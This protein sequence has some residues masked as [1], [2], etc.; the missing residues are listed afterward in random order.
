MPGLA[1]GLGMGPSAASVA[2]TRASAV[3]AHLLMAMTGLMAFL[4]ATDFSF[5]GPG[6]DLK[7][8]LAGGLG[9]AGTDEDTDADEGTRCRPGRACGLVA[10]AAADGWAAL[11]AR[12]AAAR[13]AGRRGGAAVAGAERDEDLGPTP[14]RRR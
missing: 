14:R 12:R 8:A 10:L 3:G 9:R 1:R 13:A 7:Q 6:L 2:P 5:G 11:R 4:V